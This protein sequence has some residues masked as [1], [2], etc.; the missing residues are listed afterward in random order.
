MEL[1]SEVRGDDLSADVVLGKMSDI[2]IV[3]MP[4]PEPSASS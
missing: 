3:L 4:L 2:L 1:T